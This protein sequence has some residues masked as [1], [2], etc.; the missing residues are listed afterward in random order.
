MNSIQF[1]VY[2]AIS[3]INAY[4]NRAFLKEKDCN[5]K[6]HDRILAAGCLTNV[7]VEYIRA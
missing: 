1:V 6:L 2:F 5:T 4:K 3:V 7:F